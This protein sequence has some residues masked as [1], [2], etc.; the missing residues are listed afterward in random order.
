MAKS[1][2][3]PASVPEGCCCPTGH[4]EYPIGG[5]T[6]R[7]F[8]AATGL[9]ASAGLPVLAGAAFSVA[10]DRPRRTLVRKPLVVQ[11]V[12]NCDIYERKP[13]TSWRVTGAIQTEDELRAEEEHI[14]RDLGAMAARADFP[15]EVRPLVTVRTVEQA[16]AA[17]QGDYDALIMYAAR[18]NRPVLEALARPDKW[19]LMFV[20]HRSGPLYYMYIGAHTHFLRK[21]RDAFGQPGMDVRDIVVDDHGELLW[22]LRALAGLKNTLGRRIVAVG[23][24][25]G[26]GADGKE[27]PG[28]AQAVWKFEIVP[29]SYAE[30]GQ[31]ILKARQDEALVRRAGQEAEAY[32]RADGVS[33]ETT[34]EFYEKA[35]VLTEVFRDLVAEADADAITIN[36]CMSTIMPVSETTACLPLTLLNDEGCPAFCESDFVAIPAGLLLH[37][38]SGKPVFLCNPS[39]P[40]DGVLTVSHCTAPRR[41]DGSRLEPVRVLT[42]YESDFGAATKVEMRR[43]QTITVLDP[44]FAGKR[45][46]GFAAEIFDTPFYPICRT[47]LDL[48]ILGDWERLADETRG[49]H[50]L[51]AYGDYLREVGYALKKIGLDWLKIA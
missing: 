11:P 44:D 25:A 19:N 23:G 16:T 36:N 22:R 46:L 41:M 10:A 34:R 6:R 4:A 47:Q 15:M 38:I 3:R 1:H 43:G 26:W 20:R 39:M 24:A 7:E 45:W 21:T 18:R 31:R 17:A 37:A 40:H 13:A 27:A 14:R 42:H 2:P 8:L 5:W 28:R 48:R 12:F 35:F 50:W 51:V 32:L 33:L 30:L 49:F 29:V 9:A